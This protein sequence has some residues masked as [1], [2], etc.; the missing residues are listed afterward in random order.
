M[1]ASPPDTASAATTKNFQNIVVVCDLKDGD[2]N[3]L[4]LATDLAKASGAR[5]SALAILEESIDIERVVRFTALSR[6]E[7]QKRL[8]EEARAQLKSIVSKT[9]KAADIDIDV[10]LGKPFLEI[11]RDVIDNRRDLVMKT[12]EQ[13]ESLPHFFFTSTDQHLLRKCPCPVWLLAPGSKGVAK[14]VLAAVDVDRF[15]ASEPET[16][17]ALNQAIIETAAKIAFFE[18]AVLHVLHVWD[19]L[20]EGL[21]R[22]WAT[23]NDV[24][25]NYVREAEAE[26]WLALE[27][28][29]KKAKSDINPGGKKRL[30]CLPHLVRGAPRTVVP[31]QV[32]A[33]HADILVMGTVARTGVPGLI[34]GNTAEDVL[35]SI[36]CSVVTVK[37][38]GYVSPVAL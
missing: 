31:E 35:N 11:I 27:A 10:R 30:E 2:N 19:A 13:A 7:A 1:T 21:V 17:A 36:E 6:E 8:I 14:A 5:L 33:L 3:I 38:P 20:A 22:R 26:N 29:L 12:A 25:T 28:L 32:K 18:G 37:P 4:S 34:I 23:D 9:G 15:A 24:V 16:Q